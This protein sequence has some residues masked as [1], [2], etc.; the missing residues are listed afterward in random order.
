MMGR[1]TGDQRQLFYAFNLDQLIPEGHRLRR[2]NPIARRCG[3][4]AA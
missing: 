2:I 4:A 1:Q 3:Q